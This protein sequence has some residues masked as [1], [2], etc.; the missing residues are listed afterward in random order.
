MDNGEIN[1]D[2]VL[3]DLEAKKAAIDEAI[4]GIRRMMGQGQTIPTGGAGKTI[5]PKAIPSDAF[6]GMSIPDAVRKYLSIVRKPH[7][8]K[9]IAEAL[10]AGGITHSSNDFRATV[11]TTMGRMLDKE[12]GLARIGKEYGLLDWYP[13]RKAKISSGKGEQADSIKNDNGDPQQG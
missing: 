7:T 9:Q 10:E 12:N 8:A 5:N 11:S 1:Y 4:A 2:A 6:F 3:A 13:G